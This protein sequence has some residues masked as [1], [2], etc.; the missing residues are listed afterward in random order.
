[1]LNEEA[2]KI[3]NSCVF[4]GG[5][6][7]LI[8][9]LAAYPER[10][11][12]VFRPTKPRAK[13]IQNLL[14]SHEVRFGDALEFIIRELIAEM[15]FSNLDRNLSIENGKTLSIDQYFTKRNQY[16]FVE[17]KIRDDHDS[18]KKRGQIDNFKVKLN[19]LCNKHSNNLTGI[20][21]FIDPALSKNKN[22]YLKELIWLEDIYHIDLFL[23]YGQELFEY[24]SY[25]ILWTRLEEWIRQW[26]VS[27]PDFPDIDFDLTPSES[28][29]EIKTIKPQ[30][31]NKIVTNENIWK[32]GIIQVLFND[33]TTLRLLF[34]VIRSKL[35]TE[36]GAS[37][38]LNPE[39]AVH[40]I[41]WMPSTFCK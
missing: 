30:L 27:S 20:M 32:D 18:S 9:K 16:Y 29:E 19:L 13:L 33:G 5:K 36:S 12:G 2:I 40:R 34:C 8:K 15:G 26:K 21:Y 24:L 35:S 31:W 7:S 22:F 11:V 6:R 17:Q 14:Q 37:C 4:E 25:P 1:M 39:H 10:Y 3:L 28:F 23:F 41:R 38:P